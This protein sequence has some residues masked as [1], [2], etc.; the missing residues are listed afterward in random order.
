MISIYRI[1]ND[2]QL[3]ILSFT[4]LFYRGCDILYIKFYTFS[5]NVETLKPLMQERACHSVTMF[6][7]SKAA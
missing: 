7:A 5:N 3:Q 2:I 6:V 1:N 4:L